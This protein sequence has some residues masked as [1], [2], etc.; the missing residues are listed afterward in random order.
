VGYTGQQVIQIV[1]ERSVNNNYAPNI[2]KEA[3]LKKVT[4]ELAASKAAI[5]A[6]HVDKT[7]ELAGLYIDLKNL[8]RI[9]PD[10][11]PQDYFADRDWY[12]EGKNV[13]IVQVGS[14]EDF[15]DFQGFKDR[16]SSA[17]IH[18]DDSGDLECTYDIP[19]GD[20]SSERLR[21][22]YGDGGQFELNGSPFQTDLY[23]RFENPFLRSG[24]VE[25]GQREYVIEYR[26]KSLLHDFSDF[27]QPVRQEN[28][29]S[30][31]DERNLVKALVIF[32]RTGDEDMDAF[33]V[34]TADVGIGCDQVTKEQ[35]VATGPVG[36]NT[37]HDAE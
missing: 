29:P 34:A 19:R 31:A 4:D 23:P 8:Q 33:T 28:A 16:V 24:R 6:K 13:W 9:W 10:P 5:L 30:T 3:W 11:L 1:V 35:V 32:L 36:E 37:Y 25:W 17:R 20:G 26:G 21:L 12:V 14:R 15:R 7:T 2:T 18:L 27:E 22:A